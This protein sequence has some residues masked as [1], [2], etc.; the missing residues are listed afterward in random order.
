MKLKSYKEYKVL[1]GVSLFPNVGISKIPFRNDALND[2]HGKQSFTSGM[3][4]SLSYLSSRLGL[5][6]S[7]VKIAVVLWHEVYCLL[8]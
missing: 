7:Y 4:Y 1:L 6:P 3:V 8:L 2:S 5:K